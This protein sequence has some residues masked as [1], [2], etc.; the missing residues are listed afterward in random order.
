MPTL[1]VALRID[2]IWVV[3]HRVTLACLANLESIDDCP[4]LTHL[5][6]VV[7]SS[8]EED[9]WGWRRPLFVLFARVAKNRVEVAVGIF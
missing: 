7:Q 2:H 8:F 9:I 6:R 4:Y 5:W 1:V 3:L